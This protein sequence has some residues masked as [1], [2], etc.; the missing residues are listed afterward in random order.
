MLLEH[1]ADVNAQDSHGD[2]ALMTAIKHSRITPARAGN[3][4]VVKILLDK[5]AQANLQNGDGQTAM[6]FAKQL[7]VGN[8]D[9]DQLRS[10]IIALF[11][12]AGANE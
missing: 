9:A 2:T 3:L 7:P 8:D 6:T 4:E 1:G 12:N 10:S 5:G 11:K